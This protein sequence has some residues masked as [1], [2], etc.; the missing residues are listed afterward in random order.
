[1]EALRDLYNE[2]S[3]KNDL[4]AF[5]N[6]KSLLSA[7]GYDVSV[8]DSWAEQEY[9]GYTYDKPTVTYAKYGM[10]GFTQFYNKLWQVS[11]EEVANMLDERDG[12]FSESQWKQIE[13]LLKKRGIYG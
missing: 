6:Q 9:D 2:G 7:M 8:F 12:D 4:T 3:K 13:E 5:Y 11:K 10:D 1:M